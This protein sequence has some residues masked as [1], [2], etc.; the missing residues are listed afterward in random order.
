MVI[1]GL[2][3]ERVLSMYV[4]H[5]CEFMISLNSHHHSAGE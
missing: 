1:P 2:W 3:V 5:A 4:H